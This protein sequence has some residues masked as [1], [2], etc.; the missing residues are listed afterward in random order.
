MAIETHL[1]YNINNKG[2][3]KEIGLVC[4]CTNPLDFYSDSELIERFHFGE[5]AL[6]EIINEL[7]PQ[8]Q[9]V[10]DRKNSFGN[11]NSFSWS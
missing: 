3:S 9:H 11:V 2:R 10:L 7:C 1:N 4:D 5:R 8:L 6:F